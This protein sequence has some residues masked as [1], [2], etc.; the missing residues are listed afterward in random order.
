ME[1]KNSTSKGFYLY[2]SC[3]F[4]VL[5]LLLV[6]LVVFGVEKYYGESA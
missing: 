6:V 2:F 5:L 3:F 1:K 4:L